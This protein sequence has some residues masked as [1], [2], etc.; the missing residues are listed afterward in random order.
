M[1]Q[2]SDWNELFSPLHFRV[3]RLK[4]FLM[5]QIQ[6]QQERI[7]IAGISADRLFYKNKRALVQV[8]PQMKKVLLEATATKLDVLCHRLR[9]RRIPEACYLVKYHKNVWLVK[10]CQVFFGLHSSYP[11]DQAGS[12]LQTHLLEVGKSKENTKTLK[13]TIRKVHNSAWGL[14]HNLP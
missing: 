8:Q 13:N 3:R 6:L 2:L 7:K 9:I 1:I 5:E 14:P 10:S 12:F 11:G 4:D